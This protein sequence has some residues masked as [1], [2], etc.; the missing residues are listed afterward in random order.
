MSTDEEAAA[1][2]FATPRLEYLLT[3]MS[4]SRNDGVYGK[5]PGMEEKH[6]QLRRKLDQ[7][8]GVPEARTADELSRKLSPL[9]IMVDRNNDEEIT[10]QFEGMTRETLMTNRQPMLYVMKVMRK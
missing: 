4:T 6:E 8:S 1:C 9:G 7:F 2:Q 10:Q 3:V 5:F